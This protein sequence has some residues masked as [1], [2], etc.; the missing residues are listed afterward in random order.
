MM[1]KFMDFRF[2]LINKVF[3]RRRWMKGLKHLFEKKKGEAPEP[4]K[5]TYMYANDLFQIT[6]CIS[7]M[8]GRLD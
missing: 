8:L 2:I 6:S 3:N 5:V 7:K 4:P 1:N